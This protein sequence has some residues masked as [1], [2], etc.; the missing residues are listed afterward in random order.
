MK[1]RYP[2]KEEFNRMQYE[3]NE[4]KN[5]FP[6][7]FVSIMEQS[8]ELLRPFVEIEF[9]MGDELTNAI[10]ELAYKQFPSLGQ[11]EGGWYGRWVLEIAKFV[12]RN[13]ATNL[14]LLF[15]DL[16]NGVNR[17]EVYDDFEAVVA[18]YILPREAHKREAF[19][20]EGTPFWEQL[21]EARKM[22]ILEE[23]EQEIEADY[24]QDKEY[25]EQYNRFK[26]EFIETVQPIVFK[27]LG[28]QTETFDTEMWQL[29]GIELGSAYSSF[30]EDCQNLEYIIESDKLTEDPKQDFYAYKL[31]VN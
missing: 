10:G 24:E 27:Y 26:K 21:D 25:F 12:A 7:E 31:H 11:A 20:F 8:Y 9:P 1:K 6:Q 14:T 16:K 4:V 23:M 28:E 13:L 19:D 17:S 5:Q 2:S 18:S 3:F 30:Q 15:N 22:Q 29:Y